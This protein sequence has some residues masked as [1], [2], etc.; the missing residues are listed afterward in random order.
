[1]TKAGKEMLWLKRFLQQLGMKQERSIIHCNSQ[2]ALDLSKNAMNYSCTKHIDVK[3]HWL[4]QAVE[5]QQ[6]KLEKIYIDKNF[7]DMM[8][9]VVAQ[10]MLQLCPELI[11]MDPR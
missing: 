3:Y 7:V 1:M 9:K 10:D 5:E 2:R 8:T 6:F 11:G 4:R